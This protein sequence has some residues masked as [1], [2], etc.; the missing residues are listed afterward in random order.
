MAHVGQYY[1]VGPEL[2]DIAGEDVQM[3]WDASGEETLMIREEYIQL[4]QDLEKWRCR[5]N[6]HHRIPIPGYLQRT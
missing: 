3:E 1:Q 4:I 5:S 2:S 6:N